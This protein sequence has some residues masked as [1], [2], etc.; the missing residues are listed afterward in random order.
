MMYA[1]VT[2]I[3]DYFALSTT[4]EVNNIPYVSDEPETDDALHDLIIVDANTL[5]NHVYGWETIKYSTVD[6]E[7]EIDRYPP[8]LTS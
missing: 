3:G 4:V 1:K 2:F 5:I 8:T 6:I 7:V